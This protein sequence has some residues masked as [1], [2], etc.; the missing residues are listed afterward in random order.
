MKYVLNPAKAKIDVMER[1]SSELLQRSLLKIFDDDDDD[2]EG[3]NCLVLKPTFLK[4][5]PAML[6]LAKGAGACRQKLKQQ[7][8]RSLARVE[9][10]NARGLGS[11]VIPSIIRVAWM[12]ISLLQSPASKSEASGS[13]SPCQYR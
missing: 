7:A 1:R 10:M 13:G 12:L 3:R 4:E 9:D 5:R 2:A 11:H 8:H 6:W